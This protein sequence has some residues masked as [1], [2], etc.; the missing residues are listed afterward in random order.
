MFLYNTSF[1]IASSIETEFLDWLKRNYIPSCID[2]GFE[3]PL[4]TRVLTS[5]HP[6][7]AAFAFQVI[8]ED[9]KLIESWEKDSRPHLVSVMFRQWGEKCMAF[10]TNMEIM[11]L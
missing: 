2:H 11:E 6:D 4:L 9:M 10:S 1:H 8:S 7:C 3:K 5:I